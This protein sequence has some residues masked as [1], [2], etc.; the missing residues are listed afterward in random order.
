MSCKWVV[1]GL[2]KYF[3]NYC[4]N[5]HHSCNWAVSH[6][7]ITAF[8]AKQTTSW[9]LT[10]YCRPVEMRWSIMGWP[11]LVS[12]VKLFLESITY[13]W[14]TFWKYWFSRYVS[15]QDACDLL[16]LH[17]WLYSCTWILNECIPLPEHANAHSMY[18][19]SFQIRVIQG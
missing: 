3:T 9:L 15:F 14:D 19:T 13:L 10:C 6:L 4:P 2:R 12:F 11:W 17:A 1:V 8:Y 18:K 16:Q 7:W 5:K